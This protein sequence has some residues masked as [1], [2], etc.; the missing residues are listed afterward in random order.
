MRASTTFVPT[1]N[2]ASV[3]MNE[4]MCEIDD[5]GRKTSSVVSSK[6]ADAVATIQPSVAMLWVTPFAGPVL[7]EVKKIAAGASSGG[8]GSSTAP[9]AAVVAS[10]SSVGGVFQIAPSGS[11]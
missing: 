2:D 5:A 4:P 9:S 8:F 1:E 10:P 6:P 11:P 7:P 3:H